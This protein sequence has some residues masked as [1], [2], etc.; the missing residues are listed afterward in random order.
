M[1]SSL[2]GAELINFLNKLTNR[3]NSLVGEKGAKISGGE[4]QRIAIARS[5]YINPEIIIFDEAT[6]GLDLE[7]ENRVIDSIEKLPKDKTIIMV[8]H[9]SSTLKKCNKI[10][11][12]KNNNL[13]LI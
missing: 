13:H 1:N 5:L 8:S 9:R 7:T 2:E 11:E 6:S 12:I 10:Y 4:R 3:E